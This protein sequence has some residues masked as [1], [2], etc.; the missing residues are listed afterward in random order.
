MLSPLKVLTPSNPRLVVA[1]IVGI[2][3]DVQARYSAIS[4]LEDVAETAARSFPPAHDLP[5]ILPCEV[6]ST[7]R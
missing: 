1:R 7:T 6:P 4:K 3:L 5:D 2:K